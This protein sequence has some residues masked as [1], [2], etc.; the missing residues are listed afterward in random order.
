M[1]LP[2]ML[3]DLGVA[4]RAEHDTARRLQMAGLAARLGF[5][6]VWVPVGP[7]LSS[8]SIATLAEQARPAR[9]GLVL[10]GDPAETAERIET[11]AAGG[12]RGTRGPAGDVLL[13]IHAPPAA[14]DR[15]VAATGGPEGWRR[16][17][18][19]PWYDPEAAGLVVL[20][21]D[22]GDQV[23]V[24]AALADGVARRRAAGAD[25][26]QFPISVALT[27]SIGRTMSEAE[28]RA[29][30]D[31]AL[32]GARHPRRAGLF[33]TLEHAQ[34]QALA[35]AGAG[36]DAVRATLADERDAADLLAQLR[37]VA[38]GPTAVLHARGD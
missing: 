20:A 16:R 24:R 21:E 33:G 37:A 10:T 4:L 32:S 3:L 8:A 30:R 36:A 25:H 22:I 1:S 31:P 5:Q 15:L 38:V 18:I 26:L 9:V 6:Y 11:L 29:L 17:A 12:A 28:A 14:R 34:E 27:V 23:G 19:V 7:G 2:N 35:L 13:E